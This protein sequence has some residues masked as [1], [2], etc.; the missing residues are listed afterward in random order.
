MPPAGAD[1]SFM[2]VEVERS[3]WAATENDLAAREDG[4]G[5]DDEGAGQGR[6]SS[7]AICLDQMDPGTSI[8]MKCGHC[9]HTKC[10]LISERHAILEKGLHVCPECR[11]LV[12]FVR[13]TF[14]SD[15]REMLCLDT[16]A[17]TSPAATAP[18]TAAGEAVGSS[19]PGQPPHQPEPVGEH[20]QSVPLLDA[21]GV[22]R[23]GPG[24]QALI[25]SNAILQRTISTMLDVRLEDYAVGVRGPPPCAHPAGLD[26]SCAETELPRPPEKSAP[27]VVR[28]QVNMQ[29]FQDEI[30]MMQ[31]LVEQEHQLQRKQLINQ[32]R[33]FW[34]GV[35]MFLVMKLVLLI[36][37]FLTAPGKGN[38]TGTPKRPPEKAAVKPSPQRVV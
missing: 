31:T 26:P 17:S 3:A 8:R 36:M 1:A 19:G 35:T 6:V 14:F 21:A 30:I 32:R 33:R 38:G 28:H 7:C 4:A 15:G 22:T 29:E 34:I 11:G 25:K 10:A 16:S 23:D 37:L 9:L 12:S 2:L 24:L 13:T 5:S 27:A 20:D 18:G